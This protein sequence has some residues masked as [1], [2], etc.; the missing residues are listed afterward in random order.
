MP[1]SYAASNHPDSDDDGIV[2]EVRKF[3]H[4]DEQKRG[5]EDAPAV[6]TPV[7]NGNRSGGPGDAKVSGFRTPET[8]RKTRDSPAVNIAHRPSLHC[9][10]ISGRS[11]SGDNP[12][13][14]QVFHHLPGAAASAPKK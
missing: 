13:L 3:C 9:D 8:I 6:G 12:L 4:I 2:G 7:A 1:R 14:S 5:D 10:E 11:F